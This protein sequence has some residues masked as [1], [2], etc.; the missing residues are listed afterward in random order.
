MLEIKDLMQLLECKKA[1]ALQKI[2]VGVSYLLFRIMLCG[3]DK[4]P[5]LGELTVSEDRTKVIIDLDEKWVK[6]LHGESVEEEIIGYLRKVVD[7]I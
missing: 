1:K 2:N 5:G 3:K 6:L 4:V 7:D